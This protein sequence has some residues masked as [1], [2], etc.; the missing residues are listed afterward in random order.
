LKEDAYRKANPDTKPLYILF[1]YKDYNQG[2]TTTGITKM[3]RKLVESEDF[4]EVLSK[5]E[6]YA[7]EFTGTN[8]PYDGIELFDSTSNRLVESTMRIPPNP[9]KSNKPARKKKE[10]PG[11]ER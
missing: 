2:K 5:Y 10:D 6:K 3:V 4:R 8:K 11:Y 7:D 9:E 1:G